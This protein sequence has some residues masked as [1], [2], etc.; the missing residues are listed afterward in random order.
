MKIVN[1]IRSAFEKERPFVVYRKPLSEK[2]TGFFQNSDELFFS[3]DYEETG[4][5]FAPFDNRLSTILIPEK[6]SELISEEYNLNAVKKE[7]YFSIVHDSRDEHIDLVEKTIQKIRHSGIQKIVVSRKEELKINHINYID[8]FLKLLHQ[9]KS[10]MVYL[11]YHPKVGL[12]LGAT[13]ETLLNISDNKFSTM[14]LAAT[15]PYENTLD[16]SWSAKELEEQALVTKF[17]SSQLASVSTSLT[18]ED[19]ETVRAGSM[20]HLRTLLSGNL[21]KVQFGLKNLITILHPTP[22]VC[23]FPREA[24]RAYILS[25]EGYERK[26][27]TGFLG[28]INLNDSSELFVNLRCMEVENSKVFLYVGGGITKDSDAVKEWDET[29]L[30]TNTLKKVL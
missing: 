5:V 13:P 4:F 8:V 2:V 30:K 16:V 21:N 27:Y 9:Y 26:F 10:A 18:I 22:A 25:H 7:S 24:A 11:F 23:G 3:L 12:W 29:V 1:H 28:E 6:H 19:R 15:K 17:I 20:V 14:S